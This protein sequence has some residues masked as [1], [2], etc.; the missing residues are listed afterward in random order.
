ML[1]WDS[2]RRRRLVPTQNQ[3][4]K[5]NWRVTIR[6][7]AVRLSNNQTRW[8]R[9]NRWGRPTNQL[10]VT[11]RSKL[12]L[13]FLQQ[14][15]TTKDLIQGNPY[16][17]GMCKKETGTPSMVPKRKRAWEDSNLVPT[18]GRRHGQA[19]C[20]TVFQITFNFK[21]YSELYSESRILRFWFDSHWRHIPFSI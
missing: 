8:Y 10:L 12:L 14:P 4:I 11:K 13:S 15:S 5:A 7:S 20:T 16:S 2:Q 18:R 6:L 21:Q 3:E 1:L 19:I 9:G 17:H